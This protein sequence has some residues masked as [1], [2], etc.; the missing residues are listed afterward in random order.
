[1]SDDRFRADARAY[2]D[3]ELSAEERLAFE[4]HV[5]ANPSRRDELAS[6]VQTLSLLD[7]ALA[8]GRPSVRDRVLSQLPPSLPSSKFPA[9]PAAKSE[10][11]M[12][13]L[14]S[15]LEA[16]PKCGAQF[17][18]SAM[19]SGQRFTCGACGAIVTAG[20]ARAAPLGSGAIPSRPVPAP[21]GKPPG[22]RGAQYV[23]PER[24]TTPVRS[25]EHAE[26]R[27]STTSRSSR[28][29]PPRKNGLS[30]AAMAG[31]GGGILALAL[32]GLMLV[33]GKDTKG[34]GGGSSSTASTS[35]T[36][37][38]TSP[39]PNAATGM[40]AGAGTNAGAGSGMDAAMADG[41]A[42]STESLAD[43]SA[44]WTALGH[45]TTA[46]YRQ[47]L[48]RFKAVRGGTDKAKEIA[49]ALLKQGDKD[50]KD[51][52]EILGHKEFAFEVPEEISFKKY[53]F[54]RA[55][56]DAHTQRWFDDDESY[57]L[58]M[59][60]YEKTLIHAKRL[61]TEREYQ[62]LDVARRGID[63]DEHFKQYNYDAIFASPYLICYSSEER[64]DEESLIKLSRTER[65]KKLGELEKKREEYQ[66]IL[67]E[68]KM[69]YPQ[70]YAEFLK[71]YGDV[72]DLHPLM[73]EFGG[74][75]DYPPGKQTY[76]EGCPLI[77]WI[78]SDKKA[79]NEY[80]DVVKKESM[81]PGVAGYFSPDTGW[82]YLYD[83]DGT[84][85]EFEVNKNVHEGTHQLQHWFTRQKNEWGRPRVPQSFF[86]EGFA[87]YMGSVTM[88]KDRT[89]KFIGLN[90]PR[91]AN[92][93]SLKQQLSK[94]N[95]KL[96][97]FPLKELTGFQGYSNVQAWGVQNWGINPNFVLGLFYIQSWA[98][99][100]FL[101]E[102]DNHKYQKNFKKYLDDMLNYPR[103]ADNYGAEKFKREMN[104]STE[105]DW[106]KLQKEFDGFYDK[107]IKMDVD[108]IGPK[109]PGRDDWPDYVPPSVDGGMPAAMSEEKSDS[110]KK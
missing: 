90:R 107:L 27:D 17:D 36:S 106:K 81:D 1:M 44:E 54:V 8:E 101:N 104:I 99:V 85:R 58:A 59:K 38:G 21:Q 47:Y 86:G 55:V 74:R 53:P 6:L 69:I 68:K 16:C 72:C 91:L 56:D 102:H 95:K 14:E 49:V 25:R 41:P 52:H 23:P 70:L 87:E 84:D 88:A 34:T 4:S 2:L 9:A 48:K 66:K 105:D 28:T 75:P 20:A 100:Y 42:P 12:S 7:E 10:R 67:A 71:R 39:T 96:F 5:A 24:A 45:P 77:V 40:N 50:D 31:I 76:R 82:V 65:A 43:L 11:S 15:K 32:G 51:A 94:E 92:L 33:K 110:G 29:A 78:F 61:A 97:V 46:Q 22:V 35:S 103:D 57:N 83:E 93:Q 63:R 19:A 60:A 89:L 73:D 13:R 18:V 98:F 3:G 30:P 108:K 26:A 64:F 80:H 79:F 37:K 62:A 109:P